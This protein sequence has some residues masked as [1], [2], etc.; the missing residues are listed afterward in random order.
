LNAFEHRR[1]AFEMLNYIEEMLREHEEGQNGG[2]TLNISN[3][4]DWLAT[5]A[6]NVEQGGTVR[7]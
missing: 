5:A 1:A 7:K 4:L 3:R 2:K 6:F